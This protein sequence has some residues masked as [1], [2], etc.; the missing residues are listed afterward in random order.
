MC[1]IDYI[2]NVCNAD[3]IQNVVMLHYTKKR[4]EGRKK[5]SGSWKPTQVDGK[6]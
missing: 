2:Q 1:H 5:E 3:I 6:E 4:K